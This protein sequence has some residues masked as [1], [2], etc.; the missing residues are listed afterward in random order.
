[1]ANQDILSVKIYCDNLHIVPWQKIAGRAAVY[2]FA[3]HPVNVPLMAK[4][5]LH[6]M[7]VSRQKLPVFILHNNN[8][9]SGVL[10]FEENRDIY[11]QFGVRVLP[12]QQP[13]QCW[14]IIHTKNESLAVA[15]S[16]AAAGFSHVIL[17]TPAFHIKRAFMTFVSSLHDSA[18]R[19]QVFSRPARIEDWNA[20]T[21]SHQGRTECSYSEMVPLEEER[22]RAYT[23][24]KDILP[25][26]AIL[27]Y[28]EKRDARLKDQV[29][30]KHRDKEED[31]P[32]NDFGPPR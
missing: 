25:A 7:Q 24:K 16:L 10:P 31:D 13:L 5:I 26:S 30:R 8:E 6:M 21:I 18:T 20:A 12:L 14:D 29:G 2:L 17:C 15:R 4:S 9:V 23:K 32:E 3:H 19:L 22:I 11:R 27:E 28:L 1:M